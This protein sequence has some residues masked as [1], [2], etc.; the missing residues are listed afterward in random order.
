MAIIVV[1]ICV[2]TCLFLGVKQRESWYIFPAVMSL[3]VGLFVGLVID[4]P[5]NWAMREKTDFTYNLATLNDGRETQG[6]FFLGSGTIDSVP[7][8]MFYEEDGDGYVLRDWP[9]SSSRVVETTGEPHVVYTC[10]DYSDVPR[11]FRWTAVMITEDGDY[12]D[13][14]HAFVTFYVPPGSVKREVTLDAQ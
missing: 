9:A 3:F 14:Q 8:F 13:C 11:P 1:A 7:S 6:S 2:L 10:D 12:I 5:V 4:G